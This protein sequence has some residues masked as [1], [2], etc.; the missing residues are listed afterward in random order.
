MRLNLNKTL[1]AALIAA[2]TAVGT[3]LP[4][5]FAAAEP[6]TT[7][8]FT[9]DGWTKSN[10]TIDTSNQVA[11][12]KGWNKGHAYMTL[13]S[14]YVLPAGQD[15]YLDFSYQID[16]NFNG[17][18]T[19]TL[20]DSKNSISLTTGWGQYNDGG[21]H[22]GYGTTSV[23]N[24]DLLYQFKD[25]GD[26]KCKVTEAGYFDYGSQAQ[27][28]TPYTSQVDGHIAWDDTKSHYVLTLTNTQQSEDP[29][30][31][32][33]DLGVSSL[34]FDK[35]NI[36]IEGR[37]GGSDYYKM[38]ELTTTYAA[39]TAPV[40]SDYVWSGSVDANWDKT[41][42]NWLADEAA[43]AY[44]NGK[45]AFFTSA[46]A[47]K[48][49]AV[50]DE[51]VAGNLTVDNAEYTFNIEEGASLSIGKM[52]IVGSASKLSINSVEAT[53][54]SLTALANEG[55]LHLGAG[56]AVVATGSNVTL[57]ADHGLGVTGE[58]SISIGTM[59]ASGGTHTLS[60]GISAASLETSGGANVTFNGTLN[61]ITGAIHTKSGAS[62]SLSIG[63]GDTD[64]I[65]V[66]NRLELGDN[67]SG[68]SANFVIGEH[69]KVVVKSANNE[70]GYKDAGL[71][72]SEWGQSTHAQIAGEL[73]AKDAMLS[74]GDKAAT[75]DISGTVATKG[76]RGIKNVNNTI[77]LAEGGVLVLGASG[78]TADNNGTWAIN[79]NG[80]EVG[81]SENATITRALNVA[82]DVTFNTQL[83]TWV[84]SDAAQEIEAG[85][86]GGTMTVSGNITG[87]GTITKTG[88]G[89]LILSGG[90]NVINNTIQVQ[91]GTLTMTGTY[92][93]GGIKGGDIQEYYVDVDDKEATNG[94]YCQAGS[95][96]VYSAEGATVNDNGA[97]Y[98][99]GGV[100]VAVTGGVITID[101]TVD[102]TTLWVRD[103]SEAFAAY[104][105][106]AGEALT[107]VDLAAGTSVN[108]DYDTASITLEMHGDATVNATEAT[109]ITGITGWSNN[110]L[111]ITG[112]GVVTLPSGALTLSGTTKLDVQGKA[113][114]GKLVLNNGTP[115]LSVAA[116]ASLNVN[117]D[118][119]P[120]HGTAVV[121][122]IVNISG[123]L[124]L[125]N[126]GNSDVSLN[127]G[128]TGAVTAGS[129]WMAQA[130]RVALEENGTFN[131]GNLQIVGKEGGSITTSTN[132]VLYGS[133]KADFLITNAIVTAN[134]NVT[135]G[136]TLS[137]VNVVTGA[138]T[139]TL[140]TD[141][142]STF[143]TV[144]VSE[145]GSLVVNANLDLGKLTSAGAITVNA[146]KSLT[147]GEGSSISRAISNSGSVTMTG[148]DVS[149]I[150][151]QGGGDAYYDLEGN[152]VTENDDH[153]LGTADKYVQVV[154]GGTSSGTDLIWGGVNTWSLDGGRFVT[155]HG[156]YTPGTYYVVSD[157]ASLSA[158]MD[159]GHAAPA[160]IEVQGGVLDLDVAPSVVISVSDFGYL[161]GEFLNPAV[162]GIEEESMVTF[163]QTS[164]ETGEGY[165]HVSVTSDE[166]VSIMNIGEG[167][168][169]YENMG[170]ESAALIADTV[171]VEAGREADVTIKNA[172][173]VG[174]IT[175]NS[176][177]TLYL[178]GAV[179]TDALDAAA[180]DITLHNVAESVEV[181][182]L[183]IG[184]NVAVGAY[185]GTDEEAAQEATVVISQTL[186]AGEAS[187]L[188]ANLTI[189]GSDNAE[190]PTQLNLG[191]AALTLG[192]TLTVDTTSGLILLDAET[193]AA[194]EG[195]ALGHNLDLFTAL[196][197]THLEYG[198]PEY[199]GTWFDAMF[200]RTEGVHGDY[201][202]Y[203]TGESFG[204]TKVS[205][206]P[207]PTT[208]TLSLLALM[209][210]AARRR[211]H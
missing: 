192:S 134:G 53:T 170:Q 14:A 120:T 71:L 163:A 81:I 62:T 93:I 91:K 147:F 103:G 79:L 193:I 2:I 202:V 58:G 209:A 84:G 69:G 112:T 99:I 161:T 66:V 130:A 183:T 73:Y 196:E 201:L 142:D 167:K 4:Q 104:K 111:T 1:R 204:L 172:L 86:E 182:S 154:N 198:S 92:E 135:I 195:L 152:L 88:A 72:F 194:L 148:V 37:S 122:G 169:V 45:N 145:N 166:T 35:V 137:G 18:V 94:F 119:T 117:G 184:D 7:D 109:S 80:G 6:V 30:T 22:V 115:A 125:S 65:L 189:I 139:V 31:I 11:S 76:I 190:A 171:E 55:E 146:E 46:G 98:T 16:L 9:V 24:P 59:T 33:Y 17:C 199:D 67:A 159:A 52:D 126:G 123:S 181:G 83:Y 20:I 78:I 41:T 54:L 136:N 82:G 97:K 12:N 60:V 160:A 29:V 23:T 15:T 64:A 133:N 203:A 105:T 42:E 38:T 110:T 138:H 176:E 5:S 153:Y 44:V 132:N 179:V 174:S 165:E 96:T 57:T 87:N 144:T 95:K 34:N 131:I 51:I 27:N 56:V 149:A 150:A 208:G 39:P 164:I 26:G 197:E 114:T 191:G 180:G 102:Y 151:E 49:V 47:E 48:T 19:F 124:D 101:P 77:N 108:M 8:L 211:K 74:T 188:L 129:M 187:I 173:Y 186:T 210:L 168:L 162:V 28:N 61:S 207:E 106:K 158:I 32:T 90:S 10:M 13:D 175:N 155:E 143:G 25:T 140:N 75:I 177:H 63:T 89:E 200:V 70:T 127:I 205:N 141:A 121:N 3:T 156:S 178:D 43:A 68:G 40:V 157:G 21:H 107:K 36:C 118:L 100:E 50:K 116:G 206:V 85:Q 185:Q 113:A 128:S